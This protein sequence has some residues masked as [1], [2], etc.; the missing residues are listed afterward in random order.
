[1]PSTAYFI[2]LCFGSRTDK[3]VNCKCCMTNHHSDPNP[4]PTGHTCLWNWPMTK[5]VFKHQNSWYKV[6]EVELLISNL[7]WSAEL[8]NKFIL[9]CSISGELKEIKQDISSLRFELLEEKSHNLEDLANLIKRLEDKLWCPPMNCYDF[10]NNSWK[11]CDVM[12]GQVFDKSLS[13]TYLRAS[14]K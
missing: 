3:L 6:A 14:N 12:W 9:C 13:R 8:R 2:E 5:K 7:C 1:M 4:E 10:V 11:W